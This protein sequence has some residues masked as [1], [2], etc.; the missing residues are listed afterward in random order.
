LITSPAESSAQEY[1]FLWQIF[2]CRRSGLA[3]P[4]GRRDPVYAGLAFASTSVATS[5]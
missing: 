1:G 4:K 5:V 3:G 2:A